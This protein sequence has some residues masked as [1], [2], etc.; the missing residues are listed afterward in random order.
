MS[1]KTTQLARLVIAAPQGRSGKTTVSLGLCAALHGRGLTVQPFK[2]GPDY[3]DPSWLGA[4]AGRPCRSLEP[5]FYPTSSG[6]L[7]AFIHGSTRADLSL[8]EGNHGLFDSS[9]AADGQE[10]GQGS[11]AAVARILG[12]PI[13]LVV[14]TTRMSRSAAAMVAG[15]QHFEP[16][17]PLAGVILNHVAQSRHEEKLRTAIE[18]YTGLPV[19][20]AIPRQAALQ[21][22]DRHLGL[23][24]HGEDP[25]LHPAIQA[26]RLAVE[27][28]LDLD[29]ILALAHRASPLPA[30]DE[31]PE[32]T[33]L[34]TQVRIGVVRDQA[35]TFYYSENLE[36]LQEA[37]AELVE[38]DALKDPGLPP[39][40][41]LIIGGGF[42][43]IFLD[44]LEGN[45]S[46]RQ[47]VR[48]AIERGLPVYAECGG[49]MY[50][51]Q[52]IVWGERRAEM[53]GVLPYEIEMDSRPQGHGYAEAEVIATN[54][55]FP[56]GS[57][58][59][60]HEFHHSRIHQL[61]DQ[62]RSK[63]YPA[64]RLLRGAG[65]N[66]RRSNGERQGEDGLVIHNLLA[67]YLHLHAGGSPDWA[68]GLVRQAQ[69]FA[70]TREAA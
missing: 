59:R 50:L 14:N 2:K 45:R 55:F 54:P 64:Y 4:A 47:D 42:P 18:G 65:L 5:Y 57:R 16:D 70:R 1:G 48:Q 40:D 7:S 34:E 69:A 62:D 36:A 43:E 13:L 35:F 12:A 39:I 31:S 32:P 60:G 11:T 22:P 29:A 3:I 9:L 26:C 15:Y 10:D 33:R 49:L 8:I 46:F 56:V 37:G 41:A 53:V 27:R 51:S 52:A 25:D 20:G 63:A 66:G 19:V 6:L 58:L 67:S 24:P 28:Y 23:V 61:S 38:I 30:P 21:I 17:T 68:P 44:Q